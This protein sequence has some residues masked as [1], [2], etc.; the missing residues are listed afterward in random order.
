MSTA[1]TIDQLYTPACCLLLFKLQVTKLLFDHV[2]GSWCSLLGDILGALPAALMAQSALAPPQLL[3]AFERWLLLLKVRA[4]V[5]QWLTGAEHYA[6]RAG[7]RSN[8]SLG[9]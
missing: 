8:N 4:F 5:A 2:W 3:L 7:S 1:Q 6:R 9:T